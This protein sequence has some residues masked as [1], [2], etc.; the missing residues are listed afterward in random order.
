MSGNGRVA[1]GHVGARCS[2]DRC[3]GIEEIVADPEL[4]IDEGREIA[5]C[6]L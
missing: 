6:S 2:G 1:I 3:G 5:K 4:A